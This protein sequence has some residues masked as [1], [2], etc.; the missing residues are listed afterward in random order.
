MVHFIVHD[1]QNK[2]LNHAVWE[3]ESF[4]VALPFTSITTNLRTKANNHAWMIEKYNYEMKEFYKN[5]PSECA[6]G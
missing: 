5:W 3:N 1:I 4:L 6:A 2:N